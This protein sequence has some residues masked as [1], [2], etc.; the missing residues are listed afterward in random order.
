LGKGSFGTV[1]KARNRNTGLKVAIK[2]IKNI[3]KSPYSLRKLIREIILLRKLSEIEDNNFTIKLVDI[4]IPSTPSE[5]NAIEISK[6][7]TSSV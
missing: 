4:I 3:D 2:L 5:K 7:L 6:K 1:L